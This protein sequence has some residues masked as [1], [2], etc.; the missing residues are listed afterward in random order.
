M[1]GILRISGIWKFLKFLNFLVYVILVVFLEIICITDCISFDY[2][3]LPYR[4][5]TS[6]PPSH[7]RSANTFQT[8][9]KSPQKLIPRFFP[10]E[11]QY[12]VLNYSACRKWRLWRNGGEFS[13]TSAIPPHIFVY[14]RLSYFF[15]KSFR[16]LKIVPKVTSPVPLHCKSCRLEG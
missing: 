9:S 16:V 1:A 12:S 3:D 4:L 2:A 5:I 15:E 13:A 6:S 10:P 7:G 11:N 14:S 8:S